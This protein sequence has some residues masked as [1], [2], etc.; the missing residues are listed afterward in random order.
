MAENIPAFDWTP[1]RRSQR[2]LDTRRQR[3]A[4]SVGSAPAPAGWPNRSALSRAAKHGASGSMVASGRSGRALRFRPDTFGDHLPEFLA[5]FP[6]PHAWQTF[7]G[8]D[9]EAQLSQVLGY[10]ADNGNLDAVSWCSVNRSLG[11][12][13]R[14][15]GNPTEEQTSFYFPTLD[16]CGQLTEARFRDGVP[17][18][19]AR[20]TGGVA[21][22]WLPAPEATEDGISLQAAVRIGRFVVVNQLQAVSEQGIIGSSYA[23]Q[24]LC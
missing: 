8:L 4:A 12:L 21:L 19:L 20:Y 6:E 24:K 18:V 2:T 5:S 1:N 15:L 23:F 16:E 22:D 11:R 14:F 3:A 7:L 10:F 9:R 13:G 17:I